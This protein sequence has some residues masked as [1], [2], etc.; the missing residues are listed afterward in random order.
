MRKVGDDNPKLPNKTCIMAQL[1]LLK[2][3]NNTQPLHCICSQ[4]CCKSN[5]KQSL[6][7]AYL[8]AKNKDRSVGLSVHPLWI[9]KHP[10]FFSLIFFSALKNENMMVNMMVNMT[11]NMMVVNHQHVFRF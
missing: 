9:Y 3:Q 5:Q 6:V 2:R 7:R 4:S 11:V 8:C 1:N 10:A